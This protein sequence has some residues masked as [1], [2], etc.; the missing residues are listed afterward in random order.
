MVQEGR[1]SKRHENKLARCLSH[2]TN[3]TR[4]MSYLSF[5]TFSSLE[6]AVMIL[7]HRPGIGSYGPFGSWTTLRH[8]SRYMREMTRRKNTNNNP[9]S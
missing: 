8:G 9:G 2:G 5:N 4:K 3:G 6:R 1:L 7:V